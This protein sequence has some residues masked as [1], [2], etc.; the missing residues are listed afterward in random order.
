MKRLILYI[1]L[2]AAPCCSIAQTTKPAKH[3]PTKKHSVAK[4][5][6]DNPLEILGIRPGISFDSVSG[7]MKDA[8]VKMREVREDTLSHSYADQNV[9]VYV[10]D[11]IICRLTY[12]RMTFL[13]DGS[14]RLRRLTMIPRE[15]SIA[16][17]A[18]DD[19][20]NVLLLYFG[21]KWGKP[22]L[23]LDPP[24]PS[25]RW[26]TDNIQLRGFIRRGYPMWV[27]EG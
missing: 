10:V 27:L 20:E 24:L 8:A 2:L 3:K 13:F 1:L 17:G 18:S 15:S 7:I 9:H 12:M 21:Q 11:S 22:E 26:R 6:A 25:F 14:R 4:P 16:V 5:A 19:I 23:N